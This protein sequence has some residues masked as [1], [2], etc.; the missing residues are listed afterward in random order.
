MINT[1][2][3]F[4]QSKIG[5]AITLAFLALIGFAFASMDVSSSG[6]FGGLSGTS[7][8]AVVGEE[9]VSTADLSQAAT[10]ALDQV[11][12]SN[13]T[14]SMPAF[15]AEGGLDRVLDSLLD[16]TSIAEF[17]RKYGLRAGDNLVNSEIRRI[18][19]FR[20]ADGNF[21]EETYRGVLQQQGLSE[22]DV[23]NDLAQGL[24]A[25]QVVVPV[26]LGA[27]LPDKMASRY[28]A[29]VKERRQGSL[30]L[31][32]SALFAPEK[33]PTKTEV[34]A[35]YDGNRSDYIRPERR[36]LRYATFGMDAL[37]ARA[38]PTEAE[39]RAR[40]SE[41]K[42]AYSASE[43]R[44]FT[45]VIVPTQQAAN[46]IRSRVTG[47][48]ALAAA[49]QEAGLETAQIG[50]VA[51]GDF[52]RQTSPAVAQAAF[53]TANGKIAEPARSGLGWHVVQVNNINSISGRSFEQAR[54]EILEALRSEKRRRVVN[55]LAASLEERLADG[56]SLGDVAGE[57][58]AEISSTKPV[59]A[60]G[61]VYGTRDEQVAEILRPVL[62]TAFQMEEG[63]PQLAEAVPGE[64][65]LLFETSTITPSATAPLAEIEDEVKAA[66]K[67]AQGSVAAR[68]AADRILER[69]QDGQSLAAA[70][71]AEKVSLPRPDSINLTREEVL[72]SG[73]RIIPPLAL[74]FSMAE[75]STKRLEAENN[76]GWFV[77]GLDDIEAGLIAH[78]DPLFAQAKQQF[79]Q[80]LGSEY[81]AQFI[82]AVRTDVGI[83]RN[84]DA[85]DA[86]RR[87]LVGEN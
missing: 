39:L 12:Q 38:E 68:E 33:D 56:E 52:A 75:G 45:Q 36:V 62:A 67:L 34:K 30:G 51:R 20:G 55:E 16:R 77:V 66:W 78:D 83:D 1:F 27:Q 53:D 69:V 46:A 32:P 57:V 37:G 7:S 21:S 71:A 40:Y 86:V 61:L 47:G 82:A 5:L 58:D 25:Q 23:R 85:V 79:S 50:P 18:P 6:T 63:E 28:A 8:V 73:Q 48:G 72:Q 2:R 65:F 3:S 49:A 9:R 41:N 43:E 13:P 4:F 60:A 59:T 80:T 29:L 84:E 54:G 10:N 76:N 64:T 42:A 26:A 31:L 15:I 44:T 74:F 19:G 24:L 70:F 17:G 81:T 87:L 11:R 22:A 14:I 35:F